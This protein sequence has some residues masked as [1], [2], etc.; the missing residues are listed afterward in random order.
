MVSQ[1]PII[2]LGPKGSDVAQILETTNTGNY[3]SYEE[4]DALKKLILEH[5]KA[6]TRGDLKTQPVGLQNYHRRELTKALAQLV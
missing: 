5:Y 4:K 3:F 2:A 1:R 6:F